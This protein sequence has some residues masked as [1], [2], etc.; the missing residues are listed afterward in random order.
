[1]EKVGVS[2][3]KTVITVLTEGKKLAN[4]LKRQLHPAPTSRETCDVLV[5]SILSSYENAITLLALIGNGGSTQIAVGKLFEPP[6]SVEGSPSS[7]GSDQ[8]SRDQL[9][10]CKKR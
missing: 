7:E 8:N 3:K 2:D 6:N 1:M 5:E 4:E 9:Q 10:N